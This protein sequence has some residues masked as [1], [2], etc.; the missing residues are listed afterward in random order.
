CSL[1]PR[2]WG[3]RR[4]GARAGSRL[5][6]R[7]PRSSVSRP[8]PGCSGS[9]TSDIPRWSHPRAAAGPSTKSQPG[10]ERG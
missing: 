5:S 8:E 3:W 2:R 10:W 9:S 6:R 4:S 7:S 1:P